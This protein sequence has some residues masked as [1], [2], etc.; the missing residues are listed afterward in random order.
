MVS[1]RNKE[2]CT[3]ILRYIRTQSGQIAA[4]GVRALNFPGSSGTCQVQGQ[5]GVMTHVSSAFEGEAGGPI[6]MDCIVRTSVSQIT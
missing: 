3:N 2:I 6:S 5:R 1:L 4:Y